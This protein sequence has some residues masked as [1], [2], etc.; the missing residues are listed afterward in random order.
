[1]VDIGASRRRRRSCCDA[2]CGAHPGMGDMDGE[3]KSYRVTWMI[4]LDAESPVQAAELALEIQRDPGSIA[5]IFGVQE[6]VGPLCEV[7]LFL[8]HPIPGVSQTSS[9]EKKKPCGDKPGYYLA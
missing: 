8:E 5:T 6:I 4:E 9:E 7:D 1:M 2:R 3:M